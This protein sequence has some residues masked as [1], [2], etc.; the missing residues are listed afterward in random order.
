VLTHLPI[1]SYTSNTT[2]ICL[3]TLLS[4]SRPNQVSKVSKRHLGSARKGFHMDCLP[5]NRHEST[6]AGVIHC[7]SWIQPWWWWMNSLW[8]NGGR[9]AAALETLLSEAVQTNKKQ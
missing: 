9:P 4:Q 6:A 8:S 2:F 3:T 5:P 1:I 7:K